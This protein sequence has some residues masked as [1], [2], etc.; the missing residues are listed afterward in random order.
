[1]AFSLVLKLWY[2]GG[3]SEQEFQCCN[4]D[5]LTS[6]FDPSVRQGTLP[7]IGKLSSLG[8]RLCCGRLRRTSS[9]SVKITEER[10]MAHLEMDVTF[11]LLEEGQK[12]VDSVS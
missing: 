4:A 7:P 12:Y 5:G 3:G 1:M 8:A 6:S 11:S 10:V 9:H 2:T